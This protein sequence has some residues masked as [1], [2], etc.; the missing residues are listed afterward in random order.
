M[1]DTL[2]TLRNQLSELKLKHL[3]LQLDNVKGWKVG[4]S[5]S[6]VHAQR[7]PLSD[8]DSQNI[9]QELGMGFV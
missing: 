5:E 7:A 1:D 4:V 9:L 3:V 8:F 6:F 2:R